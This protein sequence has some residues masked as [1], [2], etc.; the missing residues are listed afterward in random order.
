MQYIP[1]SS[2]PE[3]KRRLFILW[4]VIMVIIVIPLLISSFPRRQPEQLT[5]TPI[6]TQRRT[7]QPA[8]TIDTLDYFLSDHPDKGLIGTHPLSQTKNG[9][10]VY[11][12]KWA[13]ENYEYYTWDDNYIYLR[14]DHSGAPVQPYT[15]APGIWMKRYMS[16]GERLTFLSGENTIQFYDSQCHP[17]TQYSGP[18]KYIM[19]LLEHNP[20]FNAGGGLGKQ[21]VIVLSY[22]YRPAGSK[23]YEKF[24]YSKEWG[25]IRWENLDSF[26]NVIQSSEFNKISSKVTPPDSTVGCLK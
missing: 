15:F 14:E 11:Y 20:N 6:L 4:I 21:D 18:Y 8:N 23:N 12:V 22:D 25:W 7:S 24:Y 13:A 19:T 10:A 1:F 2:W 17:N 16:V 3:K 9:N 5:P 26:G